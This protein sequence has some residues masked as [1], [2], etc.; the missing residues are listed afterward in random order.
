[1]SLHV[2]LDLGGTNVKCAVVDAGLNVLAVD[3]CPTAAERGEDAVL[4]RVAALG[5]ATAAPLGGAAAAGLALPGH[6]D[7]ATGAGVLLPNLGGDWVGRPIAGPVGELLG[8]PVTLVNDVRALTLAELR[9]GAGRGAS[10][11]VCIA[12]GTGVG[13]GVVIGGRVHLGLGHAGEIGHTTVDP[14]GPLCGCGNRGCLDRMASAESIAAAAGQATVQAAAD[15]ARAGDEAAIAAF[16]R[17]GEYVG[18]VLASAIVLLW[19]ER[20]VVGGGVAD[21]GELLLGPI[22]AEIRRRACVAPV[23]DI[24]VVAAQLG[25][26]AGA[27]GAALWAAE[28]APAAALP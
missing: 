15:A 8:L 5:R 12:L 14:D 7:A 22:R 23:D 17:A 9:L 26:H 21:A 6:F 3:S 10:D 19:P 2:G 16:A 1:M 24:A 27:V 20:V 25:P 11:L 4:E 28:M 18:R 13:G